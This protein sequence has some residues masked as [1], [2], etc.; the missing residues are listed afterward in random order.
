MRRFASIPLSDFLNNLLRPGGRCE[1]PSLLLFVEIVKTTTSSA[2]K[3]GPLSVPLPPAL[4]ARLRRQAEKRQIKMATAA[5]VLLD[6]RLSELEDAVALSQAEEW[7]RA[8]AWATW[9]K[10]S[11]GDARD[12]PMA[13]FAAHAARAVRKIAR[14]GRNR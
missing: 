5:R 1:P 6:E 3:A 7:Q 12:V 10:I 4:R 13:R 11:S 9:E 8:Q 14:R 2:K